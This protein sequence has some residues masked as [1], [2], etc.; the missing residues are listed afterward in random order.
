MCIRDRSK[1]QINRWLHFRSFSLTVPYRRKVSYWH[2][3]RSRGISFSSLP[4]FKNTFP[5]VC[6][7]LM[8]TPLVVMTALVAGLTLNS[9]ATNLTQEAK[10]ASSGTE[11]VRNGRLGS[12]A[13]IILKVTLLEA[14]VAIYAFIC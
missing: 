3:T 10:G 9:S 1:I 11:I 8:P 7:G 5:A 13:R 6:C 4:C 14:L 2:P 12:D